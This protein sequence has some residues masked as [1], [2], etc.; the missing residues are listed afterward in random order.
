MEHVNS[1]SGL[2]FVRQFIIETRKPPIEIW[3]GFIFHSYN[4]IKL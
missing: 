4:G 1:F 3:D 2:N